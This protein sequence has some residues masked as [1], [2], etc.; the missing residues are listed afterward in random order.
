MGIRDRI[1]ALLGRTD[2]TVERT[3]LDALYRPIEDYAIIGDRISLALV[4]KSG[5]IDWACF[6]RMDSPSVFAAIL[7]AEKGGSWSITPVGEYR[8]E[9]Q[10]VPNTNVLETTF[11][12]RFGEATL[13]D[14]MPP[15]SIEV[16]RP[17][18]SSIF[19]IVKG[20]KGEVAFHLHF[21]PRFDYARALSLWSINEGVGVRA[22]HFDQALT[23]YSDLPITIAGNAATAD[24]VVRRGEE[25][26][27]LATY[28]RPGSLLWRQFPEDIARL[29]Q[30]G[31]E[32]YWRTWVERCS[33]DGPHGDLVR[34]SA[35]VLRLLDYAPTG[36]IAAAGTTS[37]PETIGGIRN[38]D[39]RYSWIRDAS[40][41]LYSLYVLGYP[42]EGENYLSWILDMTR[43]QPRSLKVLYGIGGEQ[44]N[45][46]FELP[47]FDG[48]KGSRPV[49]VGNGAQNQRQLDIYG[50]LLD[51]AHLLHRHGGTI[52]DELW[53]LLR[54]VVDYVCEVWKEPDYGLWE[55]RSAPRQFVYSKVM[56]WVAVDRGLRIA[57]ERGLEHDQ[58]AWEST[59]DEIRNEVLTRGYNEERGC[60][61][62][63][64]GYD[65]LDASLLALPLRRFID[66][67]DPRMLGTIERVREELALG[68][69]DHLLWRVSPSFE[70]GLKG[71]EGAF[72]LCSF[73]LVDVLAALERIEE[74]EALYDRLCSYANDVGLLAEMV[75]PHTGAHLGNF[76]QAFAHVAL[77]NAA[78]HL[79]DA[80]LARETAQTR[81]QN[82]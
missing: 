15:A 36:A 6:P 57:A 75:D 35:L 55:I 39:Y 65:D 42:E 76:P 38:W 66:A 1:R 53:P 46:E 31:T 33:Y 26:L 82:R 29:A 60:F 44:E 47:H 80:R 50:E 13:T 10:Y 61:T 54:A 20:L 51:S 67:D 56:C 40:F 45:V 8:V 59:R 63:A 58:A 34:R 72:L 52:A 69:T 11:I 68:G 43:G 30:D 37:L 17:D 41:T 23:L 32:E 27:L 79:Q 3:R 28:R 74:A 16:A 7:D 81:S 12:T 9:R 2:G 64:Y 14:F 19:R 21:E 62:Q 22:N 18:D 73:W 77:V 25:R 78:V 5:S 49:R 24:F 48:Y 71:K 4:S 70:D